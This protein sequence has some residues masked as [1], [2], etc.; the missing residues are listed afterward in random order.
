M[1]VITVLNQKGGIGKTTTA[2]TIGAGLKSRGFRVLFADLD[3]QGNLTYSTGAA[4]G[5]LNAFDLL[6]G[7]ADAGDAITHAPGGDIIKASPDLA[8][9]DILITGRRKEYRLKDALQEVA[10]DYDFCV[11][12]T[13]TTLGIIT[14]NALTAADGAI[15]PT[16]AAIFDLQGIALLRDTVNAV[17]RSSN[18]GLTVYG[19]L[20]T[21]FDGRTVLGRDM[22]EAMEAAAG[23]LST[24]VF[25]TPVRRCNA[26]P[27]AQTRQQ[28]IF[29]YKRR[30]N[31]AQDY[32]AVID[33]LLQIIGG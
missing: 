22:R 3:R 6:T 10:G 11:I 18:P 13:P 8:A 27:E 29:S 1:K 31:A 25:A 20:I 32:N 4:A 17:K 9:A 26:I 28:D 7:A 19:I 14:M 15:I 5:G 16:Q 2:H 30:S 24:R 21:G 23:A 12:D 33:E